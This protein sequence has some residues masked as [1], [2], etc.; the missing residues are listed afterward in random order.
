MAAPLEITCP[1]CRKEIKVPAEF[2]GKTIRCTNCQAAFRVPGGPAPAKPAP[3]R[4][5]GPAK[6][7]A[8][9]PANPAAPIPFADEPPKK[10]PFADDEEH[11]EA[12][13]AANP[14]GVVKESDAARCPF[15]A[16]ELDPPDAKVCL[17][18]G[19]DLLERKRHVV[20]KVYQPTAGEYFM[21][22]LPGLLAV[23]SIL[24]CAG[25][26]TWFWMSAK[27]LLD[28]LQKDEKNPITG[29]PE[30]YVQWWCCPMW[31]SI[32]SAF[33]AW[34]IG[35]FAVRRLIVNW[36]PEEQKIETDE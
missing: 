34:R 17:H 25:V 28:F 15:C 1:N 36:R 16:K 18:C 9:K 3:A 11:T 19:Y 4:P 14:Y 21:H 24:T 12:G 7:V 31:V 33:F 30:W 22:W 27:T 2:A 26:N 20:K 35:K 32:F 8:A 13:K 23:G 29:Q 6:P 10:K 5:A